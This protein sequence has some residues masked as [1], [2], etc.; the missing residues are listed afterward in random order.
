M[1]C[2]TREI[3]DLSRPKDSPS[4]PNGKAKKKDKNKYLP[5]GVGEF[6]EIL[7]W[8]SVARSTAFRKQGEG[9]ASS[10]WKRAP[11]PAFHLFLREEIAVQSEV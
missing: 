1:G 10:L 3:P 7:P 4:N 6:S 9:S 5:Q 8:Q 2:P 11:S